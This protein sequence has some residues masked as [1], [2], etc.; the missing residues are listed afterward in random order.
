MARIVIIDP[1]TLSGMA[2]TSFLFR[3]AAYINMSHTNLINHLIE[4]E[5]QSYGML[6]A[7][8]C[9]RKKRGDI[10]NSKKIRVG[11]LMGGQSNEREISLE[12]GR[13]ITYKFSPQKYQALPLFVN[14]QMELFPLPQ[15][16]LVL[17]STAQI[18]KSL[19]PDN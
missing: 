7:T 8:H 4:T 15:Q 13:N 10:M 1:N 16:Q 6:E 5:L 18:E 9:T 12:S 17:N 2:P 11:V 3:E 14:K 19:D